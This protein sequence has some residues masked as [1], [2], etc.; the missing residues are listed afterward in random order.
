LTKLRRF[1]F[2]VALVLG[3]AFGVVSASGSSDHGTLDLTFTDMPGR[4]VTD[5]GSAAVLRAV[6]PTSDGKLVAAGSISNGADDDFAVARYASTGRLDHGFGSKGIVTTPIGPGNDEGEAMVVQPDRKVVVAGTSFNGSNDEFALVRYDLDGSL[7]TSF[8]TGGV[9]LTPIG[10][11]ADRAYALSRQSDGKL[12]VAGST[13]NGSDD[14]FAVVRYNPDGSLDTTFGTNGIVVTPIGPGSDRA[15]GLTIASTGRIV[16]AGSSFNGS[17]DDFAVARYLPT[18]ALDTSFGGT[19]IVT[20][21][22]GVAGDVAHAVTVQKDGT[23]FVG[24]A[25][26]NGSNDDFAVVA[27]TAAGGLLPTFGGSG[28]VTTPVDSGDDAIDAIALQ[29]DGKLLVAGDSADSPYTFAIARYSAKGTLDAS[30]HGGTVT[31]SIGDGDDHAHALAVLVSK[32]KV[33]SIVAAGSASDG[34]IDSFALVRYSPTGI[35]DAAFSSGKGI[36]RTHVGSGDD[37]VNAVVVVAPKLGGG[38]LAA[39]A[40]SNGTND[41]FALARYMKDGSAVKSFGTHGI[42]K[43]DFGS[44]DDR[45]NAIVVQPD[46]KFVVAG[47]A[48][49]GSNKDIAL[50]RYTADGSLDSSFGSGGKVTTDVNGGDDEASA[51]VRQADGKLVVAGSGLSGGQT[52]FV[53]VRYGVN[54]SLDT[55]FGTNGVVTT[56]IGSAA[57][58]RALVVQP[59]GYLIA[60]G[61]TWNGSDHDFAVVRYNSFGSPDP[62]WGGGG[63]V[64]T[65]IGPGDDEANALV[66]QKNG[67][68]IAAGSSFNGSSDDFALVRYTANGALDSSFGSG[69]IV[70]TSFGSGNDDAYGL[71]LQINQKPVAV[72][73][74][75]TGTGMDFALARYEINGSPNLP[76]GTSGETVTPVGDG[77][78]TIYA[79]AEQVSNLVVGGSTF[80]GADTDFVLAR[81]ILCADP[82]G[83]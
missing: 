35:P 32:S 17:N 52:K 79:A 82:N 44:G 57:S 74:T 43:T 54:G 66:L 58:A 75:W 45:A 40:S 61:S 51:L 13:F 60:A 48:S 37:R 49:N 27:Y 55:T 9:V 63:I 70:T 18:G 42:V 12:V 67:R 30:F 7:D 36:V 50:V 59:N 29:P 1:A 8:G 46:G 64:T 41:D 73:A 39:G 6:A 76:F 10:S 62:Q 68:P 47:S 81:Y 69:G 5:V 23:I 21:P 28:K 80:N 26:S 65:P 56:A 22:I 15:Y 11:H 20:T 19:G 38:I 3:L 78:D 33:T 77:D 71:V 72:G 34:S 2:G 25:S 4:V 14:D 24:G 31:T 16:V 53:L 83:C